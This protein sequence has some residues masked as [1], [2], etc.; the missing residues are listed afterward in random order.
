MTMLPGPVKGDCEGTQDRCSA[1][2]CPLFGTLGKAARDG[3]R[4]V[5]GC[6][7][8]SAR[9]KR[10]RNKGD[11]K[12]TKA[13]RALGLAGPNTRHEEHWRG[14]FRVESKAG[15]QVEPIRTRFVKAEAQSF[16]GKAAGDYRPFLMVAMPDGMGDDGL[17]VCRLSTFRAVIVPL[18]EEMEGTA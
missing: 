9:G 16:E 5:R 7:D 12:A 13:R 14:A 1:P 18:I 10:N 6:G 17:V 8:P 2:G 4:R 11:R 15:A 3:G